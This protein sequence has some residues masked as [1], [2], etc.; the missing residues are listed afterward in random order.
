M[1]RLYLS[2]PSELYDLY[3]DILDCDLLNYRDADACQV[4]ILLVEN[5]MELRSVW[6]E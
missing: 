1:P 3:H 4:A 5:E 2:T 6:A